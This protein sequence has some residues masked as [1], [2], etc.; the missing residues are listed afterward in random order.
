MTKDSPNWLER[1]E[2]KNHPKGSPEDYALRRTKGAV[3]EL[4]ACIFLLVRGWELGRS[5]TPHSQADLIAYSPGGQ[6]FRFNVK[7]CGSHHKLDYKVAPGVY[8]LW[9]D[10]ATRRVSFK[11]PYRPDDLR[12]CYTGDTGPM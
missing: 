9:Y 3:A 6:L 7:T 2:A 4:I 11:N 5:V 1:E 8:A 10:P 12:H